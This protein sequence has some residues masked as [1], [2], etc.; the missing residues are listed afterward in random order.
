M[1]AKLNE[2]IAE[3][4]I[5]QGRPLMVTDATGKVF[6]VMTE[7]DFR[8]HIYDDGDVEV[9]EAYVAAEQTFAEGWNAAG[10]EAYDE[11]A[12]DAHQPDA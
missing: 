3:A 5:H 11:D 10:M 4:V 6:V 1:T 9:S 7:Q 12:E 2:E 8:R